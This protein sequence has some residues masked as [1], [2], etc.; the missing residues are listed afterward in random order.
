MQYSEFRDLH[1]NYLK[2]DEEIR[3]A[4][5]D[6][7]QFN[8]KIVGSFP[9]IPYTGTR[10]LYEIFSGIREA[11]ENRTYYPDGGKFLDIGAGTG[12]IVKLAKDFGLSAVGI[13][14]H[15]PYVIAGRKLHGLSDEEL[16]LENA[17][18]LH[19]EFLTQFQV[20]YT[21]MPLCNSDKMSELHFQI[22]RR[23][24]YEAVMVEMLPNYYPM[25]NFVIRHG[26]SVTDWLEKAAKNSGA[27]FA[28]VQHFY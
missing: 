4:L 2:E 22:F 24:D 10:T 27:R 25:D 13:E 11:Y 6:T 7:E 15:E 20:I 18:N 26:R 16:V 14:F 17:F 12:T 1:Q 28:A 23:L 5:R 9:Y 19:R 3:R 8:H 21:Y